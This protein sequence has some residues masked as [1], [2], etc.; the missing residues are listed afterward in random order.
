MF[1]PD[2]FRVQFPAFANT[3]MFPNALLDMYFANATCYLEDYNSCDLAGA[4]RVL[5]LNQM[6]AHLTQLATRYNAGQIPGLPINA[7]IDKVTVALQ[8]PPNTDQWS[9]WMNQTPYGQQLFALLQVAGC[10][11]DVVGALPEQSAF[12]KI[13][14]IF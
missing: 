6:T 3:T 13:Y 2:L 9:Y 7:T 4:C 11:V 5:A 8:P 12:K 10:H 1:D 14:G